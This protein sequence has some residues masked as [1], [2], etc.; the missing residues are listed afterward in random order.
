MFQMRN[1][2][3]IL[4]FIFIPHQKVL[5]KCDVYE[6]YFDLVVWN[7]VATDG[8]M[9]QNVKRYPELVR[10]VCDCLD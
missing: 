10:C 5:N 2:T 7:D 3:I 9:C 1:F 6:L 8:V 4:L